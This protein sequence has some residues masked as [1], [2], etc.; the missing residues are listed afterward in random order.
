VEKL[1]EKIAAAKS[2]KLDHPAHTKAVEQ[3]TLKLD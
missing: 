1:K 2:K 3:D